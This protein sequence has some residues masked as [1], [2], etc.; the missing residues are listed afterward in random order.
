MGTAIAQPR[1]V[2]YRMDLTGRSVVWDPSMLNSRCKPILICIVVNV[3][4]AVACSQDIPAEPQLPDRKEWLA[5]RALEFASY[6]FE[7][8]GAGRKLLT[9]E[10]KPVLDWS[11][12]ERNT[13]FGVT[14]VW[15]R[16]GRPELIGSAYG[17]G[18][19][20][21]H[22]FHS[23][24]TEPIVAER[25]GNRV[26]RFQ[27]GIEWREL[28]GAPEPAASSASRLTQMRRQA[29]RFE[30]TMIFRRP[31]ES[32]HPLRLL[33]RP[34]Y[35]LPGTAVNEVALFLF[36]QGTDPECVL[37]L[38]AKSD[39]TWRY[40]F[41]RQNEGSLQA[42]LDG[43]Q[44]LDMPPHWPLPGSGLPPPGSESAYI[45]VTPPEAKAAP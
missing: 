4:A 39:K 22:E 14:F 7:I 33:T 16:E 29:E 42:N 35:P 24:S 19:S 18:R 36:V 20:L 37:L 23:L 34:A 21:R 3:F 41:A 30:M 25:S 6:R 9:F 32:H 27:P 44:V 31:V 13:F 15:T 26:H 28:A 10:P 2:F 17:R 11:N 12:P 40:A 38:E 1:F 43:K 8:E 5:Q 45:T